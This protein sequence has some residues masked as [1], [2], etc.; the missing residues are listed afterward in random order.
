VTI[1][2]DL[3]EQLARFR[4]RRFLAF[5]LAGSMAWAAV[6]I[7][8]LFLSGFSIALFFCATGVIVYLGLAL[9][10][11]TG[12]YKAGKAQPK[13]VFD[14]LFFLVEVYAVTIVVL[15]RRWRRIASA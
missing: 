12:E 15:E 13:N 8:G 4:A 11:L 9:S 1:P 5:P 10:H 3:A 2:Q 14:P 6:G 7:A